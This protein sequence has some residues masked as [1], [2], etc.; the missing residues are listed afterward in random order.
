MIET[1]ERT[2]VGPLFQQFDAGHERRGGLD[3]HVDV[4]TTTNEFEHSGEGRRVSTALQID[5]IHPVDSS[6]VRKKWVMM[7]DRDIVPRDVNVEFD[8]VDAHVDRARKS[9]SRI[10]GRLAVRAS[11]G[12]D[13]DACIPRATLPRSH[14]HGKLGSESF[15]RQHQSSNTHKSTLTPILWVPTASEN[16]PP[17]PLT[18]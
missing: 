3:L 12:D 17:Y 7:N 10:F 16:G 9:R 1:V 13:L 18:T 15:R 4:A 6:A 8:S 14:V 11:M 5:R 2:P